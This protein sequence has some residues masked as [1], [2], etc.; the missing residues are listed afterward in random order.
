MSQ[1]SVV[2]IDEMVLPERGSS[3]RATQAD[4]TMAVALSAMERT[5]AQWHILFDKAGL[6][7]RKV[8]KYREEPE[9]CVM[10]LAMK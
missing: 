1:D 7:L 9:D 4:L 3:W 5:E 6:N 8:L 2:L 10:V